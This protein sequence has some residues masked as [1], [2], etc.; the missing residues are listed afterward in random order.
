M[1]RRAPVNSALQISNVE[2]AALLGLLDW[3]IFGAMMAVSVLFA[4]AV[5]LLALFMSD[6]ATQRYM[7]G[8][9]LVLLVIVVLLEGCG[10]RQM[11][12]WWGCVA[13]AQAATG[14]AGWGVIKRRAFE[15]R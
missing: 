8:R 15:E 1:T 6:L 10:Y 3:E 7:T 5:T 14:Q 11:N 9:D 12:A 13:T 4:A 2:G